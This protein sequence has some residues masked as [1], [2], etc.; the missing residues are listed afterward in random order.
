MVL[1]M[2]VPA[3][4]VHGDVDEGYG[5]VADAFRANFGSDQ[6]IGAACGIYRGGRLVVDLWGGYRDGRT[7]DPWEVDTMVSVFSATKG[8][9]A[10]AM[11]VAHR[12][13]LFDLDAP[14]ASY[15]PEFAT[16]GK[17]AIT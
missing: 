4:L 14:V 17:Q 9:A 7:K 10:A 3:D 6:E 2:K 1:R 11:A 16:N 8:M 15:W 5:P 13:G 12:G